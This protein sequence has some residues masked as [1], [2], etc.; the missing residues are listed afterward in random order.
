MGL[1]GC[2]GIKGEDE[3]KSKNGWIFDSSTPYTSGWDEVD[4]T[5]HCGAIL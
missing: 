3:A 1:Y 4:W 5:I 2:F